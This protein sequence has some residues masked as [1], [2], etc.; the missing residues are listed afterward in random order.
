MLDELQ[1]QAVA[2]S[3]SVNFSKIL[4]PEIT[5]GFAEYTLQL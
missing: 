1:A 4:R 3:W 2:K 5:S